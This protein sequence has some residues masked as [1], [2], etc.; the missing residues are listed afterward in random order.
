MENEVLN[1]GV[2]FRATDS[3]NLALAIALL[4]NPLINYIDG[5][6]GRGILYYIVQII[7][8]LFFLNALPAIIRRLNAKD[9]S[10][11]FVYI[12]L[13]VLSFVASDVPEVFS[14]SFRN[15]YLWC[16]PYFLLSLAVVDVQD[17]FNKL[18]PISFITIII[19]FLRMFTL[20][21]SSDSYSQD[22]GYDVLL[23]FM[24]FVLLYMKKKRILYFIPVV[25]SLLFMFMSGSRGPLLCAIMGISLSYFSFHKI[26]FKVVGSALVFFVFYAIYSIYSV[27]ILTYL[28]DLFKSLNVSTRSI[29]FM[30]HSDLGKD[31]ARE[32][33]R[34]VAFNYIINHPLFGTGVINDRAYIFSHY[35][36]NKT[37]TIYG[38][39][40]HNFFLEIMMQF[41]LFPGLL[42]IGGFLYKLFVIFKKSV[43]HVVKEYFIILLTIGFFPLMVSRSWITFHYFYLLLGIFLAYKKYIYNDFCQDELYL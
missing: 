1:K 7:Y 41:G 13:F 14:I 5:R 4:Y 28:L 24:V 42:I 37:A 35:V 36:I 10:C 17:L 31:V 8:L 34:E 33:L 3:V 38:S 15:I 25:L 16:F 26:D 11:V 30:L 43:C 32:K 19:V 20:N 18:T 2:I 12:I 29:D 9:L 40:C 21:F 6:L 22:L 39:Y 27:E 23:P